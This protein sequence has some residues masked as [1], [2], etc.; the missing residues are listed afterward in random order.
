LAFEELARGAG[1]LFGELSGISDAGR[2]VDAALRGDFSGTILHA[3]LAA[4]SFVPGSKVG[5][6]ANLVDGMRMSADDALDAAVDY[7][8]P[9]YRDLGEGRFAS[10][11]VNGRYSQVRMGEEDIRGLHGRGPRINFEVWEGDTWPAR[12]VPAVGASPHLPGQITWYE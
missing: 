7:L 6:A 1:K 9:A 5:K 8:G 11:T 3:G 10:Q 4:S 2:S 12:T